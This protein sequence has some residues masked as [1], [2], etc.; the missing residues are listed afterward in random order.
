MRYASKRELVERIEKEH[1]ALVA[2]VRSI[3]RS[4]YREEGVWGD[5]WTILDLLA[6][7]TEWEQMFLGWYREG[8]KNGSPDL[9][10]TG[11]KWNQ[12]PALNQ[13]IWRKHRRKSARRVVEEFEASYDE[14]STLVQRLSSEELLAPGHFAWT[15]KY[16]LTT[17]LGPN[18]C[19]HYSFATKV[20]K[21]WIRRKKAPERPPRR[22]RGV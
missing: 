3:P 6:H 21:R 15:G 2:L 7:L 20:L 13:A 22:G 12:T 18:T 9:P 14:I 11:F 10:A 4:R 1:E 16:P 19:S 8:L 17:Y 5:G